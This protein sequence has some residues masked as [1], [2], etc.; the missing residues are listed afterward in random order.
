M[1]DNVAGFYRV[2]MFRIVLFEQRLQLGQQRRDRPVE[3][4][5]YSSAFVG[6]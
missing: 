3:I 2:G 4:G 6:I 5:P 1:I